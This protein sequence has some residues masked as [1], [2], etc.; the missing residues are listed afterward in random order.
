MANRWVLDFI[1]LKVTRDTEVDLSNITSDP[2]ATAASLY[3]KAAA[4][5]TAIDLIASAIVKS[6]IK[7]YIGNKEEYGY[8][9]QALNV[10]PNPNQNA[11][12]FWSALIYKLIFDQECLVVEHNGNLY[13]ADSFQIEEHWLRRNVFV[14][15]SVEG[16]QLARRFLAD[17][18]VYL[19]TGDRRQKFLIDGMW[20]E[21]GDLMHAAVDGF[22]RSSGSKYKLTIEHYQ[23]G[24]PKFAKA[25]EEERQD[26][27]GP[28][29]KFMQ[30]ANST[31][32]QHKGQDLQQLGASGCDGDNV[33]RMRKEIF[34]LV[35][36]IF[37]IPPPLMFGNMTN[38]GDLN[39]AFLTYAVDPI[40][41]QI[42]QEFTAKFYEPEQ[43]AQ[44][45][46][47]V[48]DTTRINHID[49]FEVASAVSQ[50]IGAGFSLDEIR[51]ATR[52]PRI[53]T[54]ESQQHLI[55]RNYAPI[56]EMLRAI[57]G[58]GES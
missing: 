43:W 26:P 52:W 36:T 28:L 44:G 30:D 19:S 42:A 14:G 51:D 16:H 9:W 23:A 5:E 18:A 6:E 57:A 53:G 46:K 31:Y 55:T 2:A 38:I 33:S 40:A 4:L 41:E 56:E 50:L 45:H 13:L 22:K 17:K 35:A 15:V 37:H 49:I 27:S 10:A 24:T 54:E 11:S 20:T 25:D 48:V 1:G 47:V 3:F 7:T 39:Q 58:G 21:Y 8:L 32:I 12:Q 29:K 34:E